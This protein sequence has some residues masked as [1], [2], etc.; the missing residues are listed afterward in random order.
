M[1]R[2]EVKNKTV[3]HHRELLVWQE[4][5]AL[6]KLVYQISSSF[7]KEEQFG[8]IAQMR[9]AAVS[10]PSN[11]AEG[12]ARISRKEFVQFLAIARGSLSE[13]ETQ[14][15]I[16]Q[17]LGFIADCHPCMAQIERIF[18]LLNGLMSSLRT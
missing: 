1:T 16:A 7:P 18:R 5:I 8:L 3:R 14:I 12:A 10:V 15:V 17:E 9:R 4:A 2:D 13:L 6:V 11:I